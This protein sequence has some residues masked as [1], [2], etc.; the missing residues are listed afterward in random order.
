MSF[1]EV[2]KPFF[3]LIGCTKPMT[4]PNIEVFPPRIVDAG[5]V[6]G[7]VGILH[8][9]HSSLFFAQSN[10]QHPKLV[11]EQHN[12]VGYVPMF[13][14]DKQRMLA[15]YGSGRRG[16]PAILFPPLFHSKLE[17]RMGLRPPWLPRVPSKIRP[18]GKGNLFAVLLGPHWGRI[19]SNHL[20]CTTKKQHESPMH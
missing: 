17:T 10:F 9:T 5:T 13:L 3:T 6:Q 14:V 1:I 8:G 20:E 7:L 11:T 19:C 15:K 16:F 12:M 18:S 2:I 4:Q